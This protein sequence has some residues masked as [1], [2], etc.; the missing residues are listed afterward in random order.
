[1]IATCIYNHVNLPLHIIQTVN[2]T[3]R[4]YCAL[5]LSASNLTARFLTPVTWKEDL[6]LGVRHLLHVLLITRHFRT[7]PRHLKYT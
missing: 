6:L 7:H 2:T 3:Y 1:V 5:N 4:A